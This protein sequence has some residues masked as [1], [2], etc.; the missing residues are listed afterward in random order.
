M[1]SISSREYFEN[2]SSGK[3]QL[4]KKRESHNINYIW[5][6]H[7]VGKKF[8]NLRTRFSREIAHGV[9]LFRPFPGVHKL[10]AS[11]WR[12]A[13][14]APQSVNRCE[15]DDAILTLCSASATTTAATTLATFSL[16]G[17][18]SS[19]SVQLSSVAPLG[20]CDS[21]VVAN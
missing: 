19:D 20:R 21:R 8:L 5:A 18:L 14:R 11:C 15:G 16:F 17:N 6:P 3:F 12:K 10:F 4:S 2:L 13:K 9:F 7:R 1:V